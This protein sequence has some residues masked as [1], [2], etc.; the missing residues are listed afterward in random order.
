MSSEDIGKTAFVCHKRHFEFLRMP[1][2]LKNAPA[3]F[4]KLTTQVLEPC[5]EFATSYIDDEVIFSPSCD[6]QV[7]HVKEVLQR[8]REAG[9]TA[10]PKKGRWG[11]E[12]VEF[13][14]HRIGGGRASFPESRIRALRD[15]VKPS[16]KRGLRTFM[17]VVGFYRRYINMLAK[18]TTTLSPATAKSKPNVVTCTKEMCEAFHVI[19]QSVCDACAL[20]IPLLNHLQITYY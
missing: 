10:S 18:H 15:Y 2:G 17:G 11:C 14:G 12:M 5:A 20:E 19:C 6:A 8:L 3:V 16:T 7:G 4:Q 1:F 13:L 9:L